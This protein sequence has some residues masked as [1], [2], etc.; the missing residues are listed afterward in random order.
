M[1]APS[2]ESVRL[3]PCR[4]EMAQA[5]GI[6]GVDDRPTRGGLPARHVAQNV[7]HQHSRGGIALGSARHVELAKQDEALALAIFQKRAVLEAE[8]PVDDRQEIAAGGLLDQHGSHVSLIAAPPDARHG[9]VAPLDG[10]AVT[11]PQ[12]IIEGSRQGSWPRPASRAGSRRR[13]RSEWDDRRTRGKTCR[14]PYS[15]TRNPS[16]FSSTAAVCSKT[17]TLRP[18][19]TRSI[20]GAAP[21]SFK[22]D[23]P[24]DQDV[25]SRK[26]SGRFDCVAIDAQAREQL[27]GCALRVK[28]RDSCVG[29]RC[30][31]CSA[32][33]ESRMHLPGSRRCRT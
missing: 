2:P 16:R 10:R 7:L 24:D 23:L 5:G 26:V 30:A 17:I 33:R 14:N 6:A 11:R 27:S 20:D 9:D 19:R 21:S 1:T 22:A 28:E 18:S 4:F 13:C 32:A 25:E 29:S 12:L 3:E 8:A 31:P 15:C